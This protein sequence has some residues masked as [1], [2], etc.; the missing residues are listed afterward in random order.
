MSVVK[1]MLLQGPGQGLESNDLNK[2]VKPVRI[3]MHVKTGDTVVVI[4]GKDKGKVGEVSKVCATVC[5][6]S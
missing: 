5:K 6:L 4:A 3:P 2:N 1:S